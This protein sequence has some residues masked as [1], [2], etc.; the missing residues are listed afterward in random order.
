M[1]ALSW[2]ASLDPRTY[3]G[4]AEA[5]GETAKQ[6]SMPIVAGRALD[7]YWELARRTASEKEIERSRWTR[8]R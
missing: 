7:L 2:I 3:R 4:L 8:A 1:E 5:A 6:F